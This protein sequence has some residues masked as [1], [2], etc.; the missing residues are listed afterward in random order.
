MSEDKNAEAY[1]EAKESLEN[2]KDAVS[3]ARQEVRNFKRR[4]KIRKG[5]EPKDEK[6]K[7][8]LAG[9]EKT[10]ETAQAEKDTA[11]AAVKELKP[12]K[13]AGGGGK[14]Y[15]YGQVKDKETGEMRDLEKSEEKRW[16][17]HARK[18]AK[19][20]ENDFA[21]PSEVPFDP[22]WFDPKPKKEKKEK[23]EDAKDDAPNTADA[24]DDAKDDAEKPRKS[25]RKKTEDAEE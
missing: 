9:L 18:M 1:T 16:R 17:A 15:D 8:E 19:N 12:A 23:K 2:S 13:G 5:A 21:D 22:T 20:E 25:R 7:V 11:E 3:D 14:K 10:L 6:T 4:H 24:K